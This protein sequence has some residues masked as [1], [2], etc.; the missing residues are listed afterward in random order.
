M[1]DLTVIAGNCKCQC[2]KELLPETDPTNQCY[3]LLRQLWPFRSKPNQQVINV[4]FR[5]RYF[6]NH[7]HF[8]FN[9]AQQ[10]TCQCTY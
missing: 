1:S 9:S 10:T 7:Q 3:K 5:S 4:A 6:R 8:K 2:N